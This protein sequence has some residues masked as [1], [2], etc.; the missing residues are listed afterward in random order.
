LRY[1]LV[2]ALTAVA[3][4]E[5]AITAPPSS[6]ALR[7][8]AEAGRRAWVRVRGTGTAP[9]VLVGADGQ[10][11]TLTGLVHG[12]AALVE[13][14]DSQRTARVV[15]RLPS[16]GLVLLAIDGEGPFPAPAARLEPP[17]KG[18]W[19]VGLGERGGDPMLGRVTRA[20]TGP[21][22][23]VSLRLVPGSPLLDAQGK[24]LGVVTARRSASSRAAAMVSVRSQLER[25]P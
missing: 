16:L 4:G 19:V 21:W 11:L 10:V 24:L 6:S 2:L 20:G 9:G 12:T 8:A 5:P 15:E 23:E 22:F 3:V 13:L 14:G 18:E 25:P 7:R 17:L 1:L